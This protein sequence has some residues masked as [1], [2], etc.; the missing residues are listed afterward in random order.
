MAN[1]KNEKE[2]PE[3]ESDE[4]EG[5]LPDQ[6][7]LATDSNINPEEFEDLTSQTS[8]DTIRN[9][10]KSAQPSEEAKELIDKLNLSSADL[11]AF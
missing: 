3:S 4:N 9:L 11:E 2:K 5:N 7:D 8:A 1:Q 6:S 10:L